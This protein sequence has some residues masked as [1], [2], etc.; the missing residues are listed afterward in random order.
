[1]RRSLGVPVF[2]IAAVCCSKTDVKSNGSG[3]PATPQA[4]PKPTFTLFA[5][6]EV[7]GQIGPCG[8]TSDPLGDLSRTARMVTDARAAGPTLVVDAGSLLYSK[9]P[10]P[11]QFDAQEELKADLLATTY[12]T[13]LAVAALGLGPADLVKGPSKTRLPR[14]IANLGS[15]TDIKLAAPMI[16]DAPALTGGAKVGVF[17][18]AVPAMVAGVTVDAPERAGKEAVALLKQQGAQVIVGLIQAP[19]KKDAVK[20]MRD[21]G[22]IDLAIAGLGALAPEPERIE[23]EP[24]KV[25]DGW[26]VV[27]ANR[28]QIISRVEITL[29]GQGPLVDAIGPAAATTKL[30]SLNK[31]LA[32]LDEDLQK[33]AADPEA[34]PTFV[35]TTQEDRAQTAAQRDELEKRPLIVPASG[36]YFTL[37]QVKINKTLACAKSVDDRVT[38]YFRAAGEANVKAVTSKPPAPARGQPGYA[39]TAACEDCHADAVTFWKTTRHAHAW[40]TLVDRG[41]QFDF[42]CTSCHVTGWERPGGSN[43]VFNEPLRDVQCEVCHGPSSNHVVTGGEEKPAATLRAPVQELCANQC[44]TKEH[45]D[46]FEYTAYL[47]DILGPGH[48]EAARKKLGDGPTGAQLRKAALDKAG[49]TLGAGCSR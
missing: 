24:Q 18:V 36:S 6:A 26:I 44:H 17:G 19:S 49:R 2:L 42:D 11:A 41:Q 4:A 5:L 15:S 32:G 3:P 9:S 14:S 39:G 28:G 13:E 21:I 40:K 8:C 22:G 29:R 31:R 20:L 23:I 43:L 35:K 25:G 45:S 34:D 48:G 12:T 38:E 30:A 10:V 1:M 46:T 27:P 47:R 37:A 7:R 16:I 33:L